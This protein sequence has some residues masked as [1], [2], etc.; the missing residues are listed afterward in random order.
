MCTDQP[1]STAGI[2]VNIGV[3]ASLELVDKSVLE[4]DAQHRWRC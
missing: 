1:A 2:S 4:C 3:D